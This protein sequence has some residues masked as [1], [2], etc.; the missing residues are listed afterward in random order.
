M[1]RADSVSFR[2][3][4]AKAFAKAAGFEALRRILRGR[5][6]S[7]A[8][9]GALI[10]L[11]LARARRALA[12]TTTAAPGG[13]RGGSG[14]L[15]HP[16]ALH[17]L[18]SLLPETPDEDLQCL[19]LSQARPRPLA[20]PKDETPPC[21]RRTALS[22]RGGLRVGRGERGAGPARNTPPAAG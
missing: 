7:G 6:F 17:A 22:R 21:Q 15:P 16:A 18:L 9:C 20:A 2:P 14:A 10:D 3:Q 13:T 4:V 12:E 5:P 11:A 19:V 1:P 8:T